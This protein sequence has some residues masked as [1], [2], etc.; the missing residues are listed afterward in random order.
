MTRFLPVL[1]C[2]L[3][4]FAVTMPAAPAQARTFVSEF[5]IMVIDDKGG[6]VLDMVQR[7]QRLGQ[8]GKEVRIG[9][10]CRSACTMLI[11]LPNACLDPRTRIGF[12]A[13]R[14]PNT[15]IIPP[16]VDQIMGSFYRNDIRRNWFRGWN[17][18]VDMVIIS[19]RDFVRMDPQ[20]R[21]CGP[22][23]KRR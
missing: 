5:D 3:A 1:I 15:T 11:T 21:I 14:L 2:V 12:H 9:G 4:A 10:Y 7:R 19:A 17:R 20:T 8:S 6:N 23:K 16:Y 22:R 18:S 13:P